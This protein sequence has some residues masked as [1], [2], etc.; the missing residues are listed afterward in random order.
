MDAYHAICHLQVNKF[1]YAFP[2]LIGPDNLSNSIVIEP[3]IPFYMSF[4]LCK[5]CSSFWFGSYLQVGKWSLS[6]RG[7][8]G[9]QLEWCLI[10]QIYGKGHI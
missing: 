3:R 9:E 10:P 6:L 1:E 2:V 4:K 8:A 5:M 7:L